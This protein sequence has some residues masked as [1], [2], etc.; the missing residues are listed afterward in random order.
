M[1]TTS[2]PA[3]AAR[4][5]TRLRN[6]DRADLDVTQERFGLHPLVVADLLEGRQQPK[7]ELFDDQ[8]Y[9]TI[10][11]IDRGR[12][13]PTGTDTDLAL[14]L[15]GDELLLVQRGDVDE[16]RDLD[17]LLAGPGELP[18]VSPISAAYR[19]LAAVVR[20]FVERGAAVEA[21]LND[22]ESEVFDSRVH[23][24]YRRIYQ[25]RQR[26]GQIDRAASGLAEALRTAHD[27][28]RRLTEDAPELRPYFTHLENDARGVSELT[29][30]E[31]ESLDA[32]VS[33]HQSNVATRQNQDMRIISAF[34]ALLAIPT[35]VAGIYGMN[36]KNLPLVRWEYGWLAIG[37]TMIVADIVAFMLFRRRGWL[38]D[39]QGD[40]E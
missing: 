33:S 5:W 27:E 34:A 36:F 18:V 2:D 26:I 30:T 6:P 10:W 4:P 20:D 31:H 37:V 19:V 39:R 35:V 8:L 11:D 7:A 22:L 25:L 13:G 3:P 40:D 38:G 15:T 12:G 24:D 29:A 17:A 16:F 32:L 28:I 1:T 21:E 9:L 14:L 23:E